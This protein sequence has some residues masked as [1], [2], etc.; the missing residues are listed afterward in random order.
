MK[1]HKRKKVIENYIK[2]NCEIRYKNIV[3]EF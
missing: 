3:Q 1:F 2:Y